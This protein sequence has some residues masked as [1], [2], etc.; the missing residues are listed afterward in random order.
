MPSIVVAPEA[1]MTE[2]VQQ[3]ASIVLDEGLASEERTLP[4]T[5]APRRSSRWKPSPPSC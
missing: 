1:R 3:Q 5:R 2:E 4:E